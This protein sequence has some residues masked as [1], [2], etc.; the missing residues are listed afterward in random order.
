M[1]TYNRVRIATAAYAVVL[2]FF[3]AFIIINLLQYSLNLSVLSPPIAVAFAVLL[4]VPLA[5][6]FTWE[7]PTSVKVPNIIEINLSEITV[8]PEINL[9]AELEGTDATQ[10]QQLKNSG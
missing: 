7:R 10:L 3:M 2:V 1:N 6:A 8:R 4:A 9:S 5:L